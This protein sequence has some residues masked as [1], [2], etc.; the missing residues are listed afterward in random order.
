MKNKYKVGE[1]IHHRRYDYRGVIFGYDSKF[2]GTDA[3]YNRNRTQPRKD[4]PWYHILVDEARHTT[5]VAE[6]NLE[7]SSS[8]A[9]IDHPLA[10]KL[11]ATF[12]EGRYYNH[13]IN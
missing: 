10:E 7:L 9:P 2:R 13:S 12:H 6:E 8:R 5:Y 1:I 4:Q 11:F 3:W